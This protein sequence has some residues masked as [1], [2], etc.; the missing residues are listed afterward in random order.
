MNLAE[1]KQIG[2][3]FSLKATYQILPDKVKEEINDKWEKYMLDVHSFDSNAAYIALRVEDRK[4]KVWQYLSQNNYPLF[5]Q[6]KDLL[7]KHKYLKFDWQP[8]TA[9]DLKNLDEKEEKG[10][11]AE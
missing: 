3:Y 2:A 8:L 9:N 7:E 11:E 5:G 10:G 4:T 1:N 6:I